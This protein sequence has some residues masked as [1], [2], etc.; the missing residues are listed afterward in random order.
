MGFDK[1]FRE[2]LAD[3]VQAGLISQEQMSAM[4]A[5]QAEGAAVG[6]IKGIT[7]IAV[8]AGICFALGLVL[9]I[10]HNWDT[11]PD[12][13]K[14]LSFILI[15]IGAG[16]GALHLLPER[17]AAASSLAALWFFLPIAGIGLYAQVFQ[18]SGDA[19]KPF[20]IW[21]A[22]S[23]PLAFEWSSKIMAWLELVLL[24][25]VL[26]LGAFACDG[27][28]NISSEIFSSS[29][30]PGP[31]AWATCAAVFGAALALGLAKLPK[32]RLLMTAALMGWLVALAG[33][34]KTFECQNFWMM[35]FGFGGVGLAC[36]FVN[37][38]D[39]EGDD[40][41]LPFWIW[42][43]V[44]Y[45]ASFFY[46]RGATLYAHMDTSG[47]ILLSALFA[48]AAIALWF[49][50]KNIFSGD[51]EAETYARITAIAASALPL[52]GLF[53]GDNAAGISA[54]VALFGVSA[55]LMWHG[56]TQGRAGQ[57]NKGM[58]LLT[59][60]M[61]SRF[62]D[63]FGSLLRSGGAFMAAGLLLALLAWAMHKGR[64]ALIEKAGGAS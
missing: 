41:S 28:M 5:R 44:P 61:I 57:I 31:V 47:V 36:L 25:A 12:A 20:L 40:S 13:I 11:I 18:L 35:L 53:A 2:A 42:A 15:L 7:W 46:K 32:A 43:A 29:H 9:I 1:K 60:L 52:L 34:T 54:N 51:G 23:A 22:L 48:A 24:L 62:I 56:T 59:L 14:I 6:R 39:Q 10:S 21:A 8:M 38:Q 58:A 30:V 37:A 3:S 4:A 26:W 55:G 64:K 63:Y 49:S 19:I 50:R 27:I 16:E 17:R 45:I 33:F